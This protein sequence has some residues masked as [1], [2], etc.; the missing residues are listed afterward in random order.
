MMPTDLKYR[1][2]GALACPHNPEHLTFIVERVHG[3]TCQLVDSVGNVIPVP[4][5]LERLYQQGPVDRVYCSEC[6]AQVAGPPNKVKEG[7]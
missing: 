3:I 6:L 1:V 2:Y 4:P 7:E 5:E